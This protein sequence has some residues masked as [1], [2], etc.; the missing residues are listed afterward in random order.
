[1]HPLSRGRLLAAAGLAVWSLVASPAWADDAPTEEA[2][3]H[4]KAGIAY[5]EDPEGERIEEAHAEFQK[6]YEISHSPKVLGNIALCAMKLERDGEAIDAYTRYLKEVADIDPQERAQIARDL[7]TLTAGAVH[8]D[9]TLDAATADDVALYDSRV[10]A[11]GTSV[12]NVYTPTKGQKTQLVLRPG[13]HVM[14]LKVL[15]RDRDTWEFSAAP[16]ARM[17]HAF[18]MVEA[19]P[20]HPTD[21][22]PATRWNTLPIIVTGVGGAVL[23]VGGVLGL[24]TLTK[25]H[26]LE[27]KCPGNVCPA[28][29]YDSD[30]SSVRSYVRATD[31]LLLGGAVVTAVGLTWLVLSPST[32]ASS[33]TASAA[34]RTGGACTQTGCV[35]T[36]RVVF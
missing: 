21:N 17:A 22:P 29:E 35:G 14:T 1:M 15:G 23:V 11:R 28:S 31:F 6:A 20:T 36:V 24:A 3:R 5:L 8:V 16:G 27:S 18:H 12:L 32:T 25:I 4:F 2:R 9:V 34:V 10:P 26:N 30:V 13:H 33:S 7:Q 19:P